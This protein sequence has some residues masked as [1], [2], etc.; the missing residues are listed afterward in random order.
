MTIA[1]VGS[2][3]VGISTS[4]VVFNF[5]SLLDAAGG[6]PTLQQNDIVVIS[7]G[8]RITN[9]VTWDKTP[10]GYTDAYSTI[11]EDSTGNDL[12]LKTTYKVMGATPDTSVTIPAASSRGAS[13][14][15]VLRGVDT[16]TPIDV[17]STTAGGANAN[18]VNPNPPSITPTTAGAWIYCVG[19]V[20]S[21]TPVAAITNSPDLSSTTNHFKGAL[22]TSTVGAIGAGLKEDWASGAFD[23]AAFA[24]GAPN[25]TGSWAAASVAL[26]PA[27]TTITGT[28]AVTDGPGTVAGAGTVT[29]AGAGAIT[30]GPGTVAGAGT[31]VD[32]GTGAVSDGAEVVAGVATEPL[33]GTG[34]ADDGAEQVAAAGTVPDAGAGTIADGADLA[35]GAGDVPVAATGAIAD[36]ADLAAGAGDV[37]VTGAGAI[38]DGDDLGAGAGGVSVTGAGAADDGAELVTASD[39]ASVTGSGSVDDGSEG[40]SGSGDVTVTGAGEADDGAESVTGS[41]DAPPAVR[42]TRQRKVLL[43][44]KANVEAALPGV[45]IAGFDEDDD[46]PKRVGGAGC[47]VGHAM[48]QGEPELEYSPRQYRFRQQIEVDVA[49][50]NGAGGEDLDQLLLAIGAAITGDRT[51]GGL[52]EWVEA[53]APMRGSRSTEGVASE[54]WATVPIVAEYLARNALGE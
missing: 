45:T 33:T 9:S 41:D 4:D 15:H 12:S 23:A 48:G 28:G 10:T 37:P 13:V 39:S 8:Y 14:I 21:S 50:P 7:T 11:F 31:V 26:R 18:G 49:G 32:A 42:M 24:G 20:A 29:D 2:G 44:L 1:F 40:A 22:A 36:G 27:A 53:S 35:A 6:T 5:S 38:A 54:N 34:A 51:L 46:M 47:V 16:T 19:S 43:A 25:S 30:D 52:A 3:A 17:A